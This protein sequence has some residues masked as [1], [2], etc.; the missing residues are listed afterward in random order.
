MSSAEAKSEEAQ[1][2]LY[3]R[4]AHND[5]AVRDRGVKTLRVFLSKRRVSEVGMMK[6]WR[7]VFYCMHFPRLV[8][9]CISAAVHSD[10]DLDSVSSS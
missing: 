10:Q 3:R 5:K 4:L 8:L 2:E 7:A 6:I 9:C 1:R